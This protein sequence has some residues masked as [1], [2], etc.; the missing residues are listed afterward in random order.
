MFIARY[1]LFLSIFSFVG[2]SL[3]QILFILTNSAVFF[4]F[5]PGAMMSGPTLPRLHS[6]PRI[7]RS[8]SLTH[9]G[10]L[11]GLLFC[12]FTYDLFVWQVKV[13]QLSGLCSIF[14]ITVPS[15]PPTHRKDS[16]NIRGRW[17]KVSGVRCFIGG[18]GTLMWSPA[19]SVSV[20]ENQKLSFLLLYS[21]LVQAQ[22]TD[23]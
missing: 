23:S 8:R 19:L 10:H 11:V 1:P 4:S 7:P 3:S 12:Y 18:D 6:H 20:L 9:F 5:H 17:Q 22:G 13:P 16:I 2:F 14:Y 21:E 15:K